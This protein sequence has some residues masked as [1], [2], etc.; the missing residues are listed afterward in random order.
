MAGRGVD[1]DTGRAA[2]KTATRPIYLV[3][4][5]FPA[6]L[7]HSTGP[8]VKTLGRTYNSVGTSMRSVSSEG[9]TISFNNS[10][11][12]ASALFLGRDIRDVRC[13]VLKTYVP[14]DGVAAYA[15]V[16][17]ALAPHGETGREYMEAPL[18]YAFE[19]VVIMDGSL[20]AVS[21][22]RQQEVVVTA[23]GTRRDVAWTPRIFIGP[24]LCNHT[25]PVDSKIGPTSFLDTLING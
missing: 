20:D 21:S 19:P 7:F 14:V 4:V 17:F 10:D 9:A 8:L 25:I 12:S 11:L 2:A 16:F 5:Y 18:G 13:R 24:P 23:L 1:Y 6:P 15:P 22:V 3:E